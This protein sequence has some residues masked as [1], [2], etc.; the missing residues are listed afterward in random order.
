MRKG[1]V[2]NRIRRAR[3]NVGL[4]QAA[5]AARLGR[6]R[7][8]VANYE[9]GRVQVPGDVLARI[10]KTLHVTSDYLLGLGKDGR[11]A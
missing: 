8:S 10:A 3:Q 9:L 5:L 7:V 2:G 4:T 11:A 6:D 1:P